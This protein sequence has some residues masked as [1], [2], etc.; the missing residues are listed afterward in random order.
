MTGPA[1]HRPAM[2]PRTCEVCEVSLIG[3]PFHHRQCLTCWRWIRLGAAL[4]S[5]RRWMAAEPTR[6]RP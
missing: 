5:A 4:R 3:R 2:T 6:A 1:P